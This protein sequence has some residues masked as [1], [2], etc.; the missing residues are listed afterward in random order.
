MVDGVE[1]DG[2]QIGAVN[3][4]HSNKRRTLEWLDG[5]RH[6]VVAV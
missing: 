6:C 4:G 1:I 2:G 5:D 3:R